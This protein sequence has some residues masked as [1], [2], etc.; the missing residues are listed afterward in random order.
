M[1]RAIVTA[2]APIHSYLSWLRL[3]LFSCS[4]H[5]EIKSLLAGLVE[6]SVARLWFLV[7]FTRFIEGHT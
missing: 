2:G 1:L 6:L 5:L 3:F 4:A 7:K